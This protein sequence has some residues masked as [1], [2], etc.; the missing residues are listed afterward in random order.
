MSCGRWRVWLQLSG[1]LCWDLSKQFTAITLYCSANYFL[2]LP[3]FQVQKSSV[4]RRN[5]ADI[6]SDLLI[7]VAQAVL[8]GTARCQGLYETINITVG[9]ITWK[10]SGIDHCGTSEPHFAA[11]ILQISQVPQ[12]Q[13]PDFFS[14]ECQVACDLLGP[15]S[16][17]AHCVGTGT[18]AAGWIAAQIP[19][20]VCWTLLGSSQAFPS[21]FT[22]P[23]NV[24]RCTN[25]PDLS[26]LILKPA[27]EI[28]DYKHATQLLCKCIQWDNKRA[29]CVFTD[30][31]WYSARP[32]NSNEWERH[33]QG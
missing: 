4:F 8:G 10:S 18:G 24:F 7:S 11:E 21:L 3:A 22:Q 6:H 13:V 9:T 12:Y 15:T 2:Q 32:E 30:T 29:P 31:P 20:E 25:L 33:S 19:S 28:I 1:V 14:T 17:P 23:L 27:G 16:F 5:G 26:H